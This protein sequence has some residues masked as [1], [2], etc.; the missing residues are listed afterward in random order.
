MLNCPVWGIQSLARHLE[1]NEKERKK[2]K[3]I[4]HKKL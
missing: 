4:E 1:I 3:K 2:L